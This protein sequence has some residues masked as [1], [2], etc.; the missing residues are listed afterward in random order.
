MDNN[1][2]AIIGGA[3]FLGSR[4]VEKFRKGSILSR[5][6]D[7]DLTYNL[8]KSIY[9]DVEDTNSLDQLAG[10]SVIINLAAVP[11]ILIATILPDPSSTYLHLLRSLNSRSGACVRVSNSARLRELG[12]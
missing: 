1:E 2:V 10:A 3:G 9:L 5:K 4:L 6:Y 7:I 8:D 12:G 11:A